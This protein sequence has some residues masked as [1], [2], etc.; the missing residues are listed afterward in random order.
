MMI[1]AK[2]FYDV[3]VSRSYSSSDVSFTA[4]KRGWCTLL[5][6]SPRLFQHFNCIILLTFVY[7]LIGGMKTCKLSCLFIGEF[8][9]CAFGQ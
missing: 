9:N 6:K 5:T 3:F 8:L 1:F 2:I 4:D 7:L